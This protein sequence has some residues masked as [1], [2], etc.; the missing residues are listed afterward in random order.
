M[1]EYDFNFITFPAVPNYTTIYYYD[2]FRNVASVP[3]VNTPQQ[4]VIYPNPTHD[5]ITISCPTAHDDLSI[6]IM[7]ISGRLLYREKMSS[8]TTNALVSLSGWLP[9][10]YQ[11]IVQDAHGNVLDIQKVVK[12]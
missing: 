1:F 10:L 3:V 9:G 5:N 7:D 8:T 2:T 12:E 11:V 4:V 6:T